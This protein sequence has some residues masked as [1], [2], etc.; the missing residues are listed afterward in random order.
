MSTDSKTS[1]VKGRRWFLKTIVWLTASLVIGFYLSERDRVFSAGPVES[2][3]NAFVPNAFLRVAPDNTV[4]VG[5]E[6]AEGGPGI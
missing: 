4:A 5:P 2:A 3:A 1:A 6:H